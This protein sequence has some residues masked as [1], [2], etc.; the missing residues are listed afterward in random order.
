MMTTN[1]YNHVT[2]SGK[3]V[4]AGKRYRTLCNRY[5]DGFHTWSHGYF[6]Y[7]KQH[8]TPCP[9]CLVLV[10]LQANAT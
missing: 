8:D 3:P 10:T 6:V 9:V 1:K 4:G 5:A 2:Q 7:S